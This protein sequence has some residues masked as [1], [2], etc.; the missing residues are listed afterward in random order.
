M[1]AVAEVRGRGT[2]QRELLSASG[3]GVGRASR[4]ELRCRHR[5]RVHN[6]SARNPASELKELAVLASRNFASFY[7]KTC[8]LQKMYA[9]CSTLGACPRATALVAP[10]FL[11]AFSAASSLVAGFVESE[12]TAR[13]ISQPQS[14]W[15]KYGTGP[16]L[17]TGHTVGSSGIA[18]SPC[19]VER[20]S[21]CGH[22]VPLLSFS[23]PSSLSARASRRE[24]VEE[25]CASGGGAK[26]NDSD[27]IVSRN[28]CRCD[29]FALHHFPSSPELRKQWV[30][31]VNRKNL[32]VSPSSRV[33]SWHFVGGYKTDANNVSVLHLGFRKKLQME[34]H[35]SRAL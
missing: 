35:L 20:S 2:S 1:D 32:H 26:K 8:S 31:S 19:R 30:S 13:S 33:C 6:R 34:P 7:E 22:T 4:P 27:D 21:L 18:P 16:P 11:S 23:L 5:S 9:A 25:E 28:E 24:T 14:A 29:V 10:L 3:E 17:F 12:R 15:S